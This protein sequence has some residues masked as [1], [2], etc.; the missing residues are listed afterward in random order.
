[1]AIKRTDTIKLQYPAPGI[2]ESKR[3]PGVKVTGDIGLAYGKYVTDGTEVNGDVIEIAEI[4]RGCRV[5]TPSF[6]LVAQAGAAATF[7]MAIGD[8]ADATRY[9]TAFAVQAGGTFTLANTQAAGFDPFL[10]T[11]NTKILATLS[12]ITTPSAGKSLSFYVEFVAT[13]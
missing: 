12:G 1:M 3:A 4:P 7:S 8:A 9:S 5:L 6:R 10:L 13:T 11:E 2:N